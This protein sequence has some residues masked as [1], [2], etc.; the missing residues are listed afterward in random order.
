MTALQVE[1]SW[2]RA[3]WIVAAWVLFGLFFASQSAI[4][5]AHA[6]R[7]VDWGRTLAAWMCCAGIWALLTPVVLWLGRRFPFERRRWARSLLAHLGASAA[8][9]VASLG[10]FVVVH[11]L[12][13]DPARPIVPGAAFRS[14]LAAELHS[15][16]LLYWAILGVSWTVESQRRSRDHE[17]AAHELAAQLARARLEALERQ[18]HPHFLFNTL[19]SISVLMHA[20][21]P[22]AERMLVR[23]SGLLRAVLDRNAA[24]EVPLRDELRFLESYLEIEQVRFQ[25]RLSV[26]L[27]IEPQTLQAS[28]PRMLLQPL[29]E[30][31]LRHGIA[32][33]TGEGGRVEVRAQRSNGTLKLSVSDNGPGLPAGERSADRQGIGLSATRARLER[34]YGT[35]GNLELGDA[36]GGGLEVTLT[37]PYREGATQGTAREVRGRA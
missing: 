10:V 26:A 14:L 11:D 33:R 31:A 1:R 28:V 21:M 35:A 7:P 36:P 12:W 9:A 22:A 6:G 23:L 16:W 15:N 24:P 5:A 18:L 37:L 27:E 29:V 2:R 25:D 32:E 8:L 20:D 3:A 4:G 30:N 17:V 19:N 34:H 13:E